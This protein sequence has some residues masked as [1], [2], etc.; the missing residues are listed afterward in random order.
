[1]LLLLLLQCSNCLTCHCVKLVRS[2]ERCVVW[3]LPRL[4]LCEVYYCIIFCIKSASACSIPEWD[5]P[6]SLCIQSAL[7]RTSSQWDCNHHPFNTTL[8]WGS[9]HLPSHLTSNEDY[10]ALIVCTVQRSCKYYRT[11]STNYK[12]KKYLSLLPAFLRYCLFIVPVMMS[13]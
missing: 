5:R 13:I 11:A 10:P 1:M 8:V 12:Y 3:S 4:Y 7:G 9:R 6:V 2:V